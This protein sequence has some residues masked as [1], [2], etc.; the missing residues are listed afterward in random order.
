MDLRRLRLQEYLAGAFGVLL[1]VAT[2]LDWY[3]GDDGKASAWETFGALD[4]M[5]AAVGLMAI[6][7]AVLTAGQR[8][9]AVP[10]AIGS[11]LVLIGLVTSV[12]LAFRV[13]RTPG[14][15]PD[16]EIGLW[17]GL[18]GCVGATGSALWSIRDDRFPRAVADAGRVDVTPLP[19]PPRGGAGAGS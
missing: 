8:T 6:A 1:L 2:F 15:M 4:V 13:A 10:V 3:G 9:Q 5:L 12:W 17:L 7:L 19:A 16:R 18:V 14:D 11:L